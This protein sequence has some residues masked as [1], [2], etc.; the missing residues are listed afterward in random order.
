MISVEK[1][2]NIIL[3]R[4]K[5]LTTT[6]IP[7]DQALGRVLSGDVVASEPLPPFRAAVKDGYAVKSS[8]GP[9]VYTIAG[10]VTAGSLPNFTVQSGTVARITTGSAVPEGAD[11]V[12]MV[13]DTVLLP[14][15]P[16]Q[17]RIEVRVSPGA[18]IRP[19]GCDVA[20]GQVILKAGL[21]VSSAEIGLLATV[22]ITTVQVYGLP[23]VAVLSTGD[24]LVLHN[25]AFDNLPAGCIRDSNRPML[26]AA[27]ADSD[28]CWKN[29][30]VDLGIARD[31]VGELEAKV[32]AGLESAD[33]LITSGGVSMGEL[34]LMKP[35]LEKL[36]TVHFGRIEMKPGKP[37][38]F[39]TVKVRNNNVIKEKLVFALPVSS[40]VC[41]HLFVLPA[42]RKLAG[43]SQPLL[44]CLKVYLSQPFKQD[45]ERPDYQRA[46]AKW[47]NDKK[48]FLVT[49]TGL[50]ASCRL[51][52]MQSANVLVVLPKGNGTLPA[53][54]QVDALLIGSL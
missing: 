20:V 36:G 44:P 11:A 51:L 49:S 22:G 10:V 14:G 16:E 26:F 15:N 43:Y 40:L 4:S 31:M 52:S 45:P 21:R 7:V 54:T 50:Q 13:E 19:I 34:D 39:A 8:D 41:Y 6:T 5:T 53:G 38:T 9:G 27:I 18:E 12:V 28:P 25:V 3:E 24:E 23:K 17:V 35:L 42:L 33:V 37:L 32:V 48:G 46:I 29:E 2:L 1:A 30:C 47:D